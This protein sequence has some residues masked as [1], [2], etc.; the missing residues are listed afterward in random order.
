ME[1]PK[2]FE[3]N[4]E[5]FKIYFD[6]N[7]KTHVSEN[8]ETGEKTNIGFFGILLQ[9]GIIKPIDEKKEMDI[10][11]ISER[12]GNLENKIEDL[13]RT[14]NNVP[15]QPANEEIENIPDEPEEIEEME[16]PPKS[17]IKERIMSNVLKHSEE[18]EEMEEVQE[19]E[20]DDSDIVEESDEEI[21]NWEDI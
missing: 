5:D 14:I 12:L 21:G 7:K 11:D 8:L 2:K 20:E 1:I 9:M 15:S 13:V 18:A 17:D 10:K 19:P 3:I 6:N 16:E 4:T